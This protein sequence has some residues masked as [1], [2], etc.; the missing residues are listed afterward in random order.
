MIIT[1]DLSPTEIARRQKIS[2]AMK[3]IVAKKRKAGL[4]KYYKKKR[5]E[6]EEKKKAKQKEKERQKKLALKERNKKKPGRKKKTGPKINWYLR[7]KKKKEK[8]KRA[9]ERAAKIAANKI[10]NYRIYTTRNGNQE[11]LIGKFRTIEDAYDRFNMEKKRSEMVVF[12]RTTKIDQKIE[13]SVDECILVAKTDNGPTMLRNEYGK[14]IEHRT[15]LEG[16]EVIDKFRNRVEET[17][18]V[19]GYDNRNDRK[20]FSWIYDEMLIR[21]G[22]GLYEFRR[23]FVFRNKLLVR[24]DDGTLN[25][26]LCKSDFDAVRLYNALQDKA[27]KDG[28]KK[29]LFLGDKSERSEETDK[30]ITELMEITGWSKKKVSMKNTTY[31]VTKDL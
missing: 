4:K 9:D 21:E 29:L 6:A 18:W 1:E 19:W 30:L 20:T 31:Y 26:A 17:F 3:K 7:K 27:K 8:E 13:E 10:F 23:V 15:N 11:R 2:K 24:M 25:F 16:W 22:F 14:L 28:I 5:K 12:P